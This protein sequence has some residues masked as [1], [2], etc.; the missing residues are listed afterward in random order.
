[1]QD[2]DGKGKRASAH[3]VLDDGA[4]VAWL[5]ALRLP[6]VT[7]VCECGSWDL[8]VSGVQ[9]GGPRNGQPSVLNFISGAVHGRGTQ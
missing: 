7:N 3:E 6:T 8:G 2:M 5:V 1:M 9:Q 4:I